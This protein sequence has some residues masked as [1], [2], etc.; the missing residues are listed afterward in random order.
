MIYALS[1]A[2]LGGNMKTMQIP[3]PT[4]PESKKAELGIVYLLLKKAK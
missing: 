2:N 1:N 3:A 4:K